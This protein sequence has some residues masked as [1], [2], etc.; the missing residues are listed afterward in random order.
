MM[1]KMFIN[2]DVGPVTSILQVPDVDHLATVRS[3]R[4]QGTCALGLL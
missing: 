1:K 2:W 3:G 4:I